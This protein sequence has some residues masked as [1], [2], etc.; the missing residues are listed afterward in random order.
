MTPAE[1]AFRAHIEE[2]PFL[3]GVDRGKWG[4]HGEVAEIKWPNPLIWIC[5]APKPNCPDRVY[6]RF[7]LM[8][9]P[10]DA[11]T[12]CPWDIAKSAKLEHAKWPRGQR[13][14]SK[15]FKPGWENGKALYAPCDRLAMIGHEQWKKTHPADWWVSSDTIVKYLAGVHRLLQLED[16]VNG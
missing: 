2:S 3:E 9:Y 12:A 4:L 8:G 14:V 13:Y 11:P 1:S 7:D 15:V 10:N 16:Y 6:L 5:A